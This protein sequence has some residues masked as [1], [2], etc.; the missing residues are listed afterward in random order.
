MGTRNKVLTANTVTPT[1]QDK[2]WP[3]QTSQSP[4]RESYL[5]S[6]GSWQGHYE[7]FKHTDCKVRVATLVMLHTLA[8][9]SFP[10]FFMCF[11]VVVVLTTKNNGGWGQ[12]HHLHRCTVL[13]HALKRFM[14]F[15]EPIARTVLHGDKLHWDRPTCHKD[16]APQG[17]ATIRTL[18]H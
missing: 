12:D 9:Q 1:R 8:T 14:V 11:V 13:F 16:A 15:P 10:G 5:F 6:Q 7:N 2:L 4:G 3:L 17:D 18:K